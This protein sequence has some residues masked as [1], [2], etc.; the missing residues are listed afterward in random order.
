M[1]LL[2]LYS[3]NRRNSNHKTTNAAA[4]SSPG[5]VSS[6]IKSQRE[7]LIDQLQKEEVYCDAICSNKIENKDPIWSC[8]RCH[9]IFHLECIMTW[10]HNCNISEYHSNSNSIYR[11]CS[12]KMC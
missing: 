5:P 12:C 2:F 1:D 8:S 4:T 9:Q 7:I 6:I 3:R 10:Y 11:L